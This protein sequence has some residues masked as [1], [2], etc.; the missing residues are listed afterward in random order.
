[1]GLLQDVLQPILGGLGL[2][3]LADVEHDTLMFFV[4]TIG[5]VVGVKLLE[6]ALEDLI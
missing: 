4:A 5:I 1:M 3:T 6:L 2:P